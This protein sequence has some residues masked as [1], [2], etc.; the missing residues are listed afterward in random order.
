MTEKKKERKGQ[1]QKRQGEEGVSEGD[2]TAR[3][4]FAVRTLNQQ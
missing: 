1:R 2:K 3:Q 4:A